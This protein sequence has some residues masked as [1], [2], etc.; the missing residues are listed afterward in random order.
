MKLNSNAAPNKVNAK[1]QSHASLNGNRIFAGSALSGFTSSNKV[2]SS[3]NQLQTFVPGNTLW[4]SF[5][6]TGVS[7]VGTENILGCNTGSLA[8]GKGWWLTRQSVTGTIFFLAAPNHFI[9]FYT[10]SNNSITNLC[11]VWKISDNSLWY[12]V[13]GGTF[14][15]A[16]AAF[17]LNA[18]DSTCSSYIGTDNGSFGGIPLASGGVLAYAIWNKEASAT[19]AQNYTFTQGNRLNINTSVLSDSGTTLNFNAKRDWNGAASTISTLGSAPITLAV[20]GSPSLIKCDELR[21]PTTNKYYFDSGLVLPF[22]DGNGYRYTIRDS[23]AHVKCTTDSLYI[24]VEAYSTFRSNQPTASNIGLYTNG[25]FITQ[26]APNITSSPV[27]FDVQPGAG[28]GKIVDMWEGAEGYPGSSVPL[29]PRQ[30]T[31][32]QA[33]R[34]PLYLANG[35]S[36]SHSDMIIPSRPQKRLILVG[37]SIMTGFFVTTFTQQSQAALIRVDY[38]T[39][40]TGGVTAHCAGSDSINNINATGMDAMVASIATACNGTVSNTIWI[41]LGTNDYGFTIISAATFQTLYASFVDKIHALVPSAIIICQSPIQRIAP[42]SEGANSFGNTLGNYRT[43]I[44]NVVT[45]RPS[46]CTY[47]EGAAG[48][49]VPNGQIYVDG[50]HITAAGAASYKAFIKSTLNY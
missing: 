36:S 6:S 39:S 47:V 17:T 49:I 33:V 19:Q 40:G 41:Q 24:G 44:S 22:V 9:G 23:Y 38:P 25:T 27:L 10:P 28:T 34:L 16:S 46:F 32:I 31:P 48:A 35:S 20:S 29:I 15:S 2:Q 11:L 12:S 4:L 14:T 37:D 43:A 7:S 3:P 5:K 21:V 42:S 8:T 30:G 45:A 13:N 26:Y 18:I 50:L 1:L